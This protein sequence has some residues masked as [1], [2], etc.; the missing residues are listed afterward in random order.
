MINLPAGQDEFADLNGPIF[1]LA[2]LLAVQDEQPVQ[3]LMGVQGQA[4]QQALWPA[5]ANMIGNVIA[6]IEKRL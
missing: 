1:Q 4:L 3:H 6:M 5:A 2:G